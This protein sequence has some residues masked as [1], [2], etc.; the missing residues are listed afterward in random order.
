LLENLHFIN[1]QW[2]KRICYDREEMEKV[3]EV[4]FILRNKRD[5]LTKVKEKEKD[6]HA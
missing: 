5:K 2:Q 4:M 3:I 6:A 1:I